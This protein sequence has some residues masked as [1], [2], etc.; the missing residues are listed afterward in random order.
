MAVGLGGAVGSLVRFALLTIGSDSDS[1]L[2]LFAINV[3]GSLLLGLVLGRRE[4][5]S[6]QW[7]RGLG[8][9]VAGGLTTFSGYAVAVAQDLDD[10]SLLAATSGGL[11]TPVAALVAAGIG[12]R[13]NRVLGA[14]PSRAAGRAGSRTPGRERRPG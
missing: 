7:R 13:L 3:V 11:G 1:G 12:F 8:T 6:Q 2:I 10:G 5:L 4:H 9:G 14:R